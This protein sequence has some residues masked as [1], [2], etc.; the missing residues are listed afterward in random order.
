MNDDS[1]RNQ[2]KIAS[3]P[4]DRVGTKTETNNNCSSCSGLVPMSNFVRNDGKALREKEGSQNSNVML[5]EN[6][7]TLNVDTTPTRILSM[8]ADEYEDATTFEKERKQFFSNEHKNI[9]DATGVTIQSINDL[10][11]TNQPPSNKPDDIPNITGVTNQPS[12][13]KPDDIPNITGATNQSINDPEQT[14]QPSSNNPDDIPNVSGI[15]NPFL[16]NEMLYN[17]QAYLIGYIISISSEIFDMKVLL[18]LCLNALNLNKNT[19]NNMHPNQSSNQTSNGASNQIPTI[20]QMIKITYNHVTELIKEEE[21]KFSLLYQGIS[22]RNINAPMMTRAHIHRNTTYKRDDASNMLNNNDN[23]LY[24]STHNYNGTSVRDGGKNNFSNAPL[25]VERNNIYRK[26]LDINERYRT[27]PE[28]LKNDLSSTLNCLRISLYGHDLKNILEISDIIPSYSDVNVIHTNRNYASILVEF[29]GQL[30]HVPSSFCKANKNFISYDKYEL[31]IFL[32]NGTIGTNEAI[33]RYCDEKKLQFYDLH[34]FYGFCLFY[35]KA[36]NSMS[37]N[38]E[39]VNIYDQ[40]SNDN[41]N[42]NVP[43]INEINFQ[44]STDFSNTQPTPISIGDMIV[45]NIIPESSDQQSND[46][47]NQIMVECNGPIYRKLYVHAYIGGPKREPNDGTN[48]VF[49]KSLETFIRNN[50]TIKKEPVRNGGITIIND[51]K[52]DR[53]KK[54]G[55]YSIVIEAKINPDEFYTFKSGDSIYGI[56]FSQSTDTDKKI[57]QYLYKYESE[58]ASIWNS[59]LSNVTIDLIGICNETILETIEKNPKIIDEIIKKEVPKRSSL[60]FQDEF[61]RSSDTEKRRINSTLMQT[62]RQ[63]YNEHQVWMIMNIDDLIMNLDR[64]LDMSKYRHPNLEYYT[65]SYGRKPY[66]VYKHKLGSL[67]VTMFDLEVAFVGRTRREAERI[68]NFLISHKLEYFEIFDAGTFAVVRVGS[69]NAVRALIRIFNTRPKLFVTHDRQCAR[70]KILAL[71]KLIFTG[72]DSTRR[73][74]THDWVL[75]TGQRKFI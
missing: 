47:D 42:H 2:K 15:T 68:H 32:H 1:K 53:D 67:R 11:Q 16:G 13:N 54:E 38:Q 58:R 3:L 19:I 48:Q 59:G 17:L 6:N 34:N 26:Y 27:F 55:N 65:S 51:D 63:I 62:R 73:I 52:G 60:N 30:V 35:I 70:T 36:R 56:M 66:G 31:E 50:V 39:I 37:S 28:S 74:K 5:T 75:Y 18:N 20:D 72:G 9:P 29:N 44:E 8:S 14:N 33:L 40:L 21:R 41:A 69:Y 64:N 22:N 49:F 46:D 12:S 24:F 71:R 61:D 10:E 45:R 7:T 57:T 43:V 23:G 25:F 4:E